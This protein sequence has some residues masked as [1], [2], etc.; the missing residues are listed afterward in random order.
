MQLSVVTSETIP[1][2]IKYKLV[3]N[4]VLRC[5]FSQMSLPLSSFG[6]SNSNNTRYVRNEIRRAREREKNL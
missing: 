3:D 1:L 4:N 6:S 2:F 5:K